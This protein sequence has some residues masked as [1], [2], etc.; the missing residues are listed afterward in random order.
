M[1]KI[2]LLAFFSA[3]SFIQAVSV[4]SVEQ[5]LSLLKLG[6]YQE[7]FEILTDRLYKSEADEYLYLQGALYEK[8]DDYLHAAELYQKITDKGGSDY[9][10]ISLFR[11]IVCRDMK[12]QYSEAASLIREFLKTYPK[13]K[14]VGLLEKRLKEIV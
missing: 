9:R 10:E 2:L 12:K 7:A 5:V 13:S 6:N 1:K 4:D 3:A 8:Q 14:Y 11:L